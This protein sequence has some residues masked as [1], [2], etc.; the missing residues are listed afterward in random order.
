MWGDPVARDLG[1]PASVHKSLGSCLILA[2]LASSPSIAGLDHPTRRRIYEHLVA[3]PGDHFRSVVRTLGLGTGATRHHLDALLSLDLIYVDKSNG[4]T[5]YYPKAPPARVEMNELYAR[6]WGFRDTR[7]R[8]LRVVQRL[9]GA[10]PTKVAKSM[11]ISRQL[12]AYHL[13]QLREE[14]LLALQDGSYKAS[15]PACLND[16]AEATSA[17][18]R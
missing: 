2:S 10:T 14:G 15:G 12:A 18:G 13:K 17:R 6:H 11:G 16:T 3:L 7:G 8:I 4:R 5:R 9:D 1:G